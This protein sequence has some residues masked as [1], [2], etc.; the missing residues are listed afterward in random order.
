M[1]IGL[2]YSRAEF[3]DVGLLAPSLAY[4]EWLNMICENEDWLVGTAI[5]T[6]F[7]EGSV[8]DREEVYQQE[9]QKTEKEIDEI[10]QTHPLVVYHGLKPEHM[11]LVRAREMIEPCNR[12]VVYDM[13]IKEAMGKGQQS[14]ILKNLEEGLNL[15]LQYR[16]GIAR[17]CG[18]R[19]V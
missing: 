12:R 10:I 16:D 6:I 8:N 11:D 15:W 1:M 5:L 13:I 9:E 19:Q 3:R 7:V 4:R 2:G 17:A 18:L 14:L